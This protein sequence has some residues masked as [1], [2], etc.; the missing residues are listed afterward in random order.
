MLHALAAI[1]TLLVG[2][3]LVTS[4]SHA[5]VHPVTGDP[6]STTFT[7]EVAGKSV[8][9]TVYDDRDFAIFQWEKPGLVRITRQ[10]GVP[11]TEHRIRPVRM[12]MVGKVQGNVLEFQMDQPKPWIINLDKT[13]KLVIV[14]KVAD[15]D[16]PDLLSPLVFD[17]KKLGAD[18]TGQRDNTEL[19]QKTID[20]LPQGGTLY[21]PAGVY[22]TGS[23]NLKSDMTLYLDHDAV[24]KGSADHKQHQFHTSYLYFV[25]AQKTQ[26][27][28]ILGNGII[29]ANGHDVRQACK[30][31]ATSAR[32]P[33]GA[34][35][36]STR[37]T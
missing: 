6:I 14:P 34:W 37:R 36:S 33:A 30:R 26:N 35:S 5:A 1:V 13:R 23:I 12:G 7:V 27:L 18:S 29:D 10:D 31:N 2:S 21:F 20:T 32:S 22:R 4:T 16:F 17:V 25:R 19:I 11:I 15:P 28:K 9:V 3:L 24:L 8:P